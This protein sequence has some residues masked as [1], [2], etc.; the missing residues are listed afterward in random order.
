MAKIILITHQ[1]GGVGKSTLAFN[2]ATNINDV[3]KTCIVDLDYQGSL[4][5]IRELSNVPIF[6]EDKLNELIQS[7]FDFI[8]IDTPPYLSEKLP[9]LCNLA[10]VIV[11]PSKAGFLDI[12]AISSTINIVE[13]SGNKEKAIIVFNMVKSNTSLTD[14]VKQQLSEYNI[15]V[16]KMMISDLVAFTRSVLV[17]G[18][19]ENPNAQKQIDN[20]TK[21]ILTIAVNK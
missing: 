9:E 20:L 14:E 11:I 3:A 2:L 16:S 4:N 15:R 19:S 8:F 7:D 1:K 10:D 13:Q 17:N 12:L 6:T 5:N 21:E 18:V